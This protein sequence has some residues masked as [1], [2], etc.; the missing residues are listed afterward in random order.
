M[1]INTGRPYREVQRFKVPHGSRTALL[2]IGIH[3]TIPKIAAGAQKWVAG[4][5]KVRNTNSLNSYD[6]TLSLRVLILKTFLYLYLVLH[7]TRS[8]PD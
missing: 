5:G 4:N 1:R 2:A 8:C 7:Y 6:Y 3:A